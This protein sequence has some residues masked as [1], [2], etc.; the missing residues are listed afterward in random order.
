MRTVQ[1]NRFGG[2][3][4][5]EIVERPTPLPRP[6]QA[7]I[8]VRAAGVNFADTLMRQNRYPLTPELPSV[9]GT[10]VA[11]T[12]ERLG[13][14]VEGLETG[15][16][17]AAP[18]FAAGEYFG[19]YA[20]HVLIDA[21]YVVPLPD[22]LSFE[23]ATALMVQGLTALYLTRQ[24]PPRGRTVL[25]N[26]A[27]GGVGTLLVQL[28]RRAGAKR[29]IA[30]ASSA[31]KLAATQALGADAGVD[32]TQPGWVEEVLAQSVALAAFH[33]HEAERVPEI[34][35]VY[36]RLTESSAQQLGFEARCFAAARIVVAKD[37]LRTP[38]RLLK[39][40]R[41][42]GGRVGAGDLVARYPELAAWAS[43]AAAPPA[44]AR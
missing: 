3:E 38:K 26:A 12:I 6:G 23:T 10:E 8:R 24:A 28:A 11:G 31:R 33:L 30:A 40:A 36:A 34:E 18:L 14:E 35:H 32:Y 19:G 37:G 17:V 13:D 4:V 27:A 41:A 21:G 29:V 42:R 5:L 44:G 25:V 20:E 15:M 9:L 2:P 16:R 1:M 7:L 43:T 39:L 22:A